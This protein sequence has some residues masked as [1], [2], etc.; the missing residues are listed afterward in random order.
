MESL[1]NEIFPELELQRKMRELRTQVHHHMEIEIAER[2]E[3]DP[4]PSELEIRAGAFKEWVEPQV[5]DAVFQMLEKGY[6]TQSSGFYGK[7]HEFQAVDGY[8]AVDSKT[9]E[10]LE[11]IGVQVLNGSDLGLPRNKLIIM[12]R[13]KPKEADLQEIKRKWDEV[14]NLLPTK[15]GPQGINDRTEEFRTEHAPDHP[16]MEK[17]VETYFD[18]LR[19]E[20]G[21]KEE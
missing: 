8:F 12:L 3:R 13:F 21:I 18:G 15:N 4:R 19:R 14:A 5:R 16:N 9:K 6:G 11:Q 2:L 20:L 1:K 17:E 7:R 10:K